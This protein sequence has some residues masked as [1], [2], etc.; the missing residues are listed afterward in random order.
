MKKFLMLLICVV[1]YGNY[2]TNKIIEMIKEMENKDIKVLPIGF[3]NVFPINIDKQI[4]IKKY[5][6]QQSLIINLKAIAGNKAYINNRWYKKGDR[7]QNLIIEKVTNRC[8]FFKSM[9]VNR[10]FKIC[11]SPNIVKVSR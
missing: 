5:V 4:D 8:V 3:Y 10:S 11:L 1:L 7:I 9:E 2:K 6:E